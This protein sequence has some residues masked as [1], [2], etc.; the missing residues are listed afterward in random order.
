MPEPE[1]S[2]HQLLFFKMFKSGEAALCVYKDHVF[3]IWGDCITIN[4][5]VYYD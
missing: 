1:P 4:L 2:D 5:S 3:L